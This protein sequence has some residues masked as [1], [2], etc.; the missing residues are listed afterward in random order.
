MP[1]QRK[2]T[3]VMMIL[4]AVGITTLEYLLDNYNETI[5]VP[6]LEK[7]GLGNILNTKYQ[8]RIKPVVKA[9]FAHA[10]EQSSASA[11]SVMGHREIVGVIDPRTYDL[12]FDG[13]TQNY[14]SD[15]EKAIGKKTIF[16]KMSGGM[17]A[18]KVN[19]E[20]HEKTGK[21]IVYASKCDPIIQIAMNEA[22]IPVKEA[23]A[24]AD[25]A[26]ELA[27]EHKI[28][29]TRSIA[30]TY[31]FEDGIITRTN[32]RHD[33]VLPLEQP[34]FIDVAKEN[35]V[36]TVSIG[37]PGELIPTKTWDKK[38][39]L[40]KRSDIDPE[41]GLKFIHPQEKNTNPYTI[42]GTVNELMAAEEAY[43]LGGT[44]IFANCVDTDSLYGHR[45][46][47]EGSLKAIE[48]ASRC[49]TIVTD[50]MQQGDILL[51][52]ADHGMKHAGDYGY[53]NKEP[54][55]L[56]GYMKQNKKGMERFHVKNPNT[57]ASIA[58]VAAQALGISD[59]YI[60]QCRLQELLKRE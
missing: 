18:I 17:N 5:H 9:D 56:L 44:F 43:R 26:F 40:S 49:M 21:P 24:I 20:E 47:V 53:H 58:D 57:F 23:H 22:I 30:R 28:K 38:V 10:I 39:K 12:F 13:F 50:H 48:E 25:T 29:I 60:E 8:H 7:L 55:P 52:T 19:R 51:I 46:D 3:I 59:E 1:A 15:L 42:Q 4:D 16:N 41:L 32:N 37:K 54:V 35:G 31:T 27:M 14:I 11:D 34:T 6:T 2:P 36:Y 33:K 45:Q